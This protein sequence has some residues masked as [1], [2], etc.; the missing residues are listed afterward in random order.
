MSAGL[1]WSVAGGW[2]LGNLAWAYS[3]V[4]GPNRWVPVALAALLIPGAFLATAAVHHGKGC[5]WRQMLRVA[6]WPPKA[7]PFGW[8]R[9]RRRPGDIWDRLP[10]TVRGLRHFYGMLASAALLAFPFLLSVGA[11]RP[12]ELTVAVAGWWLLMTAGM[13]WTAWWAQRSGFPN[14]ADLR[15][16]IL[17]STTHKRFWRL[18]HVARL[19]LPVAAGAR[20]SDPNPQSPAELVRAV[21]TVVPHL[22]GPASALGAAALS[23]ARQVERALGQ[24][25]EEIAMLARDA[26]P[27]EIAAV[28]QRLAALDEAADEPASRRDLREMLTRQRD[29]LRRLADQLVTTMSR[30]ERFFGLLRTLWLQTSTL[31]ADAARDVVVDPELTGRIH[32]VVA[33]IAAYVDAV[34]TMRADAPSGGGR[35]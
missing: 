31:R 24:L 18:P 23:A 19:L 28:E 26:S 1:F 34:A 9:A 10:A 33:E 22:S 3:G 14:N 25:D 27:N 20:V 29:L 6:L 11:A 16:L 21:L 17:G 32:L 2:L 8:F 30:R 5:S 35:S 4:I 13:L 12:R 7:W 15:S